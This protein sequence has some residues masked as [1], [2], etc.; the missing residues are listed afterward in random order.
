MEREVVRSM[1]LLPM[2]FAGEGSLVRLLGRPR[3]TAGGIE[4]LR[5]CCCLSELAPSLALASALAAG[6][7]FREAHD[8]KPKTLIEDETP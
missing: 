3:P 1:L 6:S 8:P 7:R 2:G 5:G 4:R